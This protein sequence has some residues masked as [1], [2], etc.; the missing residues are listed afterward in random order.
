MGISF[1]SSVFCLLFDF[2]SDSA[3]RYHPVQWYSFFEYYRSGIK[4]V[5]PNFI[6]LENY[7]SL[8]KSDMF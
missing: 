7:I 1:Y 6:G 3:G 2:F 8:L 5:G 4:E